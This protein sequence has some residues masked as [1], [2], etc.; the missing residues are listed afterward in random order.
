MDDIAINIKNLSKSF[1]IP[2]S[3]KIH[4]R[5]YFSNPFERTQYRHFNAIKDLNFSIKKNEFFSVIGRNGAGKSTLL[6]IIA[7]I[8]EP[9]KGSIEING[10][11]V[12]FIELGVGFNT[13]L[14]GR[15]NIFLNGVFLGLSRKEIGESIDEILDFAELRD[16]AEVPVKNY[17][18]GMQVRLAF[19]V[20]I[21]ARSEILL[22]DEVLAVG[23][24]SFQRKCFAYFD[25][26][27]GKKT[28]VYVS[29]DLK[30]V[31]RYS[32]RVLYLGENNTYTIGEADKMIEKYLN[33][34]IH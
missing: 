4:L 15:E 23:D 32:N 13:E 17:S 14:S 10:K 12:P 29:H 5:D 22:L 18:S 21:K 6:K 34:A 33:E 28:I 27:L 31:S 16:F 11:M 3:R 19:S 30:S 24:E 7:G 20:A 2:I 26:I 25:S 8:Y 1:K 9:D